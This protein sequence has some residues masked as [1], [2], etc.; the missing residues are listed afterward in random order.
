V[1]CLA[2]RS[3]K[4]VAMFEAQ[5]REAADWVFVFTRKRVLTVAIKGVTE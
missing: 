1:V 5:M 3:K 4:Y 2:I